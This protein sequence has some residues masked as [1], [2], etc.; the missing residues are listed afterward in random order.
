VSP[1]LPGE[2]GPMF[3]AARAGADASAYWII[4]GADGIARVVA[5]NGGVTQVLT[6]WGSEVATI[7]TACGSYVVTTRAGDAAAGLRD[8]VRVFH[9]E[10]GRA[11]EAT[12]PTLLNGPVTALWGSAA[13]SAVVIVENANSGEY[14]ISSVG[15][16]CNR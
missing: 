9:L 14:E 4:A 16:A 7:E 2:A 1:P 5:P 10:T 8:A 15:L 3:S 12:T 6:D 13:D 11:V